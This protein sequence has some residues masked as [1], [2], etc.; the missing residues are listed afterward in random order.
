[1]ERKMGNMTTSNKV[2]MADKI[3]ILTRAIS[4]SQ[5]TS[6]RT[7]VANDETRILEVTNSDV[8]VVIGNYKKLYAAL[9]EEPSE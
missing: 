1:M 3:Q 9:T 8:D 7:D 5:K 2:E 6:K 4:V